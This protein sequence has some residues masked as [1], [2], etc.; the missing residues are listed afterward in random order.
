MSCLAYMN[1]SW[2]YGR[3]NEALYMYRL[4]T[5]QYGEC[6]NMEQN[7]KMKYKGQIW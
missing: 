3:P 1:I 2:V 4:I 7:V 6:W 5:L